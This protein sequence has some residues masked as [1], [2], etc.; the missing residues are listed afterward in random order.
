MYDALRIVAAR[1]MRNERADHTL[2]PTAVVHEAYLR[3]EAAELGD[4]DRGRLFAV[5][6]R[7]LRRVLV[8]SA[9]RR[10]AMRRGGG[11][12]KVSLSAEL[13]D[14]RE[15][16]DVLDVETCLRALR[17]RKPRAAR[18]FELRAMGGL[19][20]DEVAEVVGV[21]P[22]AVKKDWRYARAWIQRELDRGLE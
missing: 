9:R 8:D 13:A 5:A 20:N 16:L 7:M 2:D 22:E 21:G 17:K 19:N 10:H 14:E 11:G 1:H 12:V 15:G 3:L 6:A 4:I 18:V